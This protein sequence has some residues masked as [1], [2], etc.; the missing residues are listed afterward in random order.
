[1]EYADGRSIGEIIKERNIVLKGAD[2]LT[3]K[4]Y[5]MVPNHVLVSS[6]VSP[7]AKLAYAM[8]LKYAWQ[9]D[10]CYPGHER[11]ANDMGV[12][13]RSVRTYLQDQVE[14]I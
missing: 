7:G 4:G 3:A 5:T 6:K 8:L 2:V 9:N 13:D 14:Q 10:F 11:L 1:M 12:T